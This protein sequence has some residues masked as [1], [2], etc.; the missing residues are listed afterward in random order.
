[1]DVTGSAGARGRTWWRA[2]GARFLVA[3]LVTAS[4]LVAVGWLTELRHVMH[5]ALLAVAVFAL[6]PL[7]LI[8]GALL[9]VL[10]VSLAIAAAAALGGDGDADLG[11]LGTGDLAEG[12][13]WLA[14]RYYRFLGRQRHPVFWGVP[15]GLA[16][17]GLVLWGVLG[18]A[19]LPGESSTAQILAQARADIDSRYRETG[20]FP[21]PDEL[22]VRDG[23]G[24]PLEYRLS[25]RWK[26]KSWTL[27]SLGFDGE[28]SSD[29]LCVSGS[30]RMVELAEKALA[31]ASQL[32]GIRAGTASVAD[33]LSGV[34]ALRC[35]GR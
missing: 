20:D 29:D 3:A 35:P 18:L 26:L 11:G 25:G 13:V 22:V 14:P 7:I 27:V 34:R 32:E 9:L 8:G 31:I 10:V 33:Q 12:G 1:M 21:R 17:G 19:V 5:A 4:A 30:T 15:A 6:L 28:P 23:F 2:N 16:L 24:R